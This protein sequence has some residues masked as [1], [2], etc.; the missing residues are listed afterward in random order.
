M[1]KEFVFFWTFACSNISVFYIPVCI[2]KVVWGFRIRF[3]GRPIQNPAD[4]SGQTLV[5]RHFLGYAYRDHNEAYLWLPVVVVWVMVFGHVLYYGRGSYSDVG[6]YSYVVSLF[7]WVFFH[8]V[9]DGNYP[10]NYW[11]R[12]GR[13]RGYN[14]SWFF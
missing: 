8:I 11:D 9:E 14:N 10:T 6:S 13:D 2:F 4:R 5:F 7:T 3:Y 12:G 1:H